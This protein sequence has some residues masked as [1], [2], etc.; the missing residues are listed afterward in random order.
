MYM[1]KKTHLIM[2][3]PHWG[4]GCM[5]KSILA[6]MVSQALQKA[7]KPATIMSDLRATG[8][9][10][11]DSTSMDKFYGPSI[12]HFQNITQN[13]LQEEV[14]EGANEAVA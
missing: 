4:Y 7:L 8:L 13:Y 12:P 10:L 5:L 2:T 1:K 11:L 14:L 3:N 6:Q 9:F